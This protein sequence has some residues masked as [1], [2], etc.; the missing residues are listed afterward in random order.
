MAT[1]ILTSNNIGEIL[2]TNGVLN[3]IV[4]TNPPVPGVPEVPSFDLTRQVYTGRYLQLIDD[5]VPG[6]P[7]NVFCMDPYTTKVGRGSVLLN[8]A[9]GISFSQLRCASAPANGARITVTT[10]P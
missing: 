1:V 7:R 5:G 10:V 2:Q 8:N 4:L 9:A 6:L 3:S